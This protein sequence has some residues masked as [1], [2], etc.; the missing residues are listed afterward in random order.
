ML[1]PYCLILLW[2]LPGLLGAAGYRI[3]FAQ[4][5]LANDWRRA[6]VWEVQR[7]LQK[8][9]GVEFIYTDARGDTA[10]Q[11]MHIEQ[12]VRQG[13]DL[14]ITSPRDQNLLA[15]VIAGVRAQGTPV[16]LL[17]RGIASD[18]YDCFIRPD[19]AAIARKAAEYLVERLGGKGHIL[20]LQGIPEATTTRQRTQAFVAVTQ[21]YPEIRI[22][23]RVANFLRA[24]AIL[25]VEE[26]LA[27]RV[28]F[29][30]IYA[31]S[32]SMAAGARMAL[33]YQGIAPGSLPI[34]GIDYVPEARQA[35][36]AGEQSL[37]FTY[38]TG[39]REGAQMA[40][41]L[42]RGEHVPKEWL[43]ESVPVNRN[44]AA[45]VEPVF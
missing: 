34:V 24:D 21:A 2:L 44:N 4:D 11:A 28:R 27:R 45:E 37:S 9:P 26:L 8:H 5:T 31:H 30:A 39:G 36:L 40:L 20:M 38:P 41:R 3:G 12:L 7:E 19:N 14:L 16:V 23:H 33:K 10:L 22:T 29:D 42:L 15:E 32:D 25:A 17:S 1:L 18:D 43:L 13:V 35:I 6:Q